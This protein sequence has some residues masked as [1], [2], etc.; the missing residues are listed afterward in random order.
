MEGKDEE[1][2]EHKVYD[3]LRY[4]L[5]QSFKGIVLFHENL[6]RGQKRML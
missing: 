6:M 4:I 2:K 3:L 5:F 1:Y